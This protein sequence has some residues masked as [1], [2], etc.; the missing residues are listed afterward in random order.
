[1]I[2]T[3]G[4]LALWLAFV[5]CLV[6]VLLP[7]VALLD[8][9]RVTVSRFL[10][11]HVYVVLGSLGV[12]FGCLILLFVQSDFSVSVVF[13]HSHHLKPLFYKIS[14]AWGH[15]EGS[16]LLWVL[17][18]SGYMVWCAR[19]VVGVLRVPMVWVLS[20][21]TLLL[22]GF[23]LFTSHPFLRLYPIPLVGEGLNPLLQDIGLVLHPP[24]LYVGYVGM[25]VAFAFSVA[26][27][28]VGR[29]E[30]SWVRDLRPFV[31]V[32]VACLTLGIGLGSW[33]A[34][35]ELGWGGYWFWD[36][37]ENV[38]LLPWCIGVA[39][40]H[41]MTV[42]EV[43]DIYKG[44]LVILGILGFAFSLLGTFLVRS[45]LLTSVHAFASDPS[46]G[47]FILLIFM[48]LVG[49]AFGLFAVR[50]ARVVQGNMARFVSRENILLVANLLW[51]IVALTI[52]FGTIYPLVGELISGAKVSVGAPYFNEVLR[53][54]AMVMLV[55]MVIA[56]WLAW[57]KG[58]LT[59][60]IKT[61]WLGFAI[62]LMIVWL[63][64]RFVVLTIWGSVFLGLGVW[65]LVETIF[66]GW[67]T[68][69]TARFYSMVVAH[70]GIA[71]LFI[72]IAVLSMGRVEHS[73]VV[74]V[75]DEAVVGEYRFVLQDVD[76][77]HGKNY[78]SRQGAVRV[79]NGNQEIAV[80]SPEIRHYPVEKQHTTEAAIVRDWF[81]DL[82]VVLGEG[83][84][85]AR[86]IMRY[87][88]NPLMCLVWLGCVI[89][90][91]GVVIGCY[92]KRGV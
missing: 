36:P 37:V 12:A 16:M 60:A 85:D 30:P 3:I 17:I 47:L 46:R 18:L 76:Y 8:K 58:K 70:I 72:G 4:E 92:H 22:V 5:S 41:I 57:K 13:L 40:L 11:S 78:I 32:S 42:V 64:S 79:W 56:P 43:R 55:L 34:Y 89:V 19:C 21:V 14:A 50:G 65:L 61:C 88:V 29:F 52:L 51:V 67:R 73:Q 74:S 59:R 10:L 44:Q 33:W 7:A 25:V 62:S 83:R 1:M 23:L 66:Y 86:Y 49:G 20:V 28:F 80:I 81:T 82:Y 54:F 27:L 39:L 31:Q 9:R 38:S 84:E 63:I 24:L 68:G 75:G 91:A 35:R 53:P 48:V 90:A 71:F 77:S 6:A 69:R 26:V 2:A 15:H 45:G 87:Y